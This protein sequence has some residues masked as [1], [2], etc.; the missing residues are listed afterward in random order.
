MSLLNVPFSFTYFGHNITAR[1]LGPTTI[2]DIST[3]ISVHVVPF[4]NDGN[5]VGVNIVNRGW[6][7]PGG[8]VDEGELS[9]IDT[10]RREAR[11]EASLTTLEPILVDVLSLECETLDLKSRPYM[12][13]YTAE[14]A[15]LSTFTPNNEASQRLV[16][17]R[18]LFIDSYFGNK[19]YAQALINASAKALMLEHTESALAS[20]GDLSS[21]QI[22]QKPTTY[23]RKS[24][25]KTLII[26]S[27]VAIVLLFNFPLIHMLNTKRKLANVSL[28]LSSTV[29]AMGGNGIATDRTNI[30]FGV[31]KHYAN[32]LEAKKDVIEKLKIA[33]IS[34]PQPDDKAIVSPKGGGVSNGDFI[35]EIHIS[36]FP[37]GNSHTE[38]TFILER[39][40]PCG[41]EST[42]GKYAEYQC[43]GKTVNDAFKHKIAS[44]EPIS[45]VRVSTSIKY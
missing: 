24:I 28:P 22:N 41:F 3:I 36:Y 29:V 31:N 6:D 16:M 1:S 27:V 32:S 44:S 26:L 34:I 43:E 14:V 9:P 38:F 42:G 2:P 19:P 12:L 39:T 37:A 45:S 13:V 10:L 11:E 17:T 30:D 15:E 21:S 5:V 18:K 8:H 20:G 40:I 7:I 4:T 35:N 25:K 23:K 33:G